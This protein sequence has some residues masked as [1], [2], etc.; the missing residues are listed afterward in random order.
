MPSTVSAATNT[1]GDNVGLVAA[2]IAVIVAQVLKPFSEWTVTRRFKASLMVGSGGFPSSH[3]SLVTALATGAAY[4]AGLG[5]P[6]FATA[7]VLALVV[8][9]PPP[10]P[11]FFFPLPQHPPSPPRVRSPRPRRAPRASPRAADSEPRSRDPG[12]STPDPI[13]RARTASPSLPPDPR[14]ATPPSPTRAPLPTLYR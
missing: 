3:S 12:A 13:V 1:L 9:A 6:A 4:Q 8:R 7:L 2:V 10:P 5:D 11:A 14:L